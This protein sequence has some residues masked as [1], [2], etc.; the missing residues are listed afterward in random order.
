[1]TNQKPFSFGIGLSA[2]ELGGGDALRSALQQTEAWG[3]DT[4]S[5]GD[6]IPGDGLDPLPALTWAAAAT[7]RMRVRTTVIA[8]DFRNPIILAKA[9]ASIDFLSNGRLDFG[10]GAGWWRRDYRMLGVPFDRASV[11]I[12]RMAEVIEIVRRFWQGD[13]FSYKGEFFDLEQAAAGPRPVQTHLPIVIGGG[14]PKLLAVAGRHADIVGL[15]PRV[16]G[17]RI[18]AD[19]FAEMTRDEILR[20]IATLHDAARAAGRDPATITLQLPIYWAAVT[21]SD[22]ESSELHDMIADST[23]I[24]R[25]AVPDLPFALVGTPDALRDR[26]ERDRAEL[27]V[28]EFSLF[29]GQPRGFVP[30]TMKTLERFA[31]DVITPLR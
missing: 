5:T 14:G 24:P 12:R 8:A 18:S 23:G 4:F 6:H 22:R 1:M 17:G 30:V 20:K 25:D 7:T 10:I 3:Y 28:T 11:R 15:N 31:R 27:G 19:Y 29:T 2:V 26:L 21:D 16:S 9:L 13:D